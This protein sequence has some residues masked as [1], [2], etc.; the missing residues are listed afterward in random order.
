[1]YIN[2]A[3]Q[4]LETILIGLP[5]SPGGGKLIHGVEAN[6]ARRI[7]FVYHR[8][9]QA[10]RVIY[11]VKDYFKENTVTARLAEKLVGDLQSKD[12]ARQI[13]SLLFV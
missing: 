2:T 5:L 4:L 13:R 10:T 8:L 12:T 9:S 6:K 7:L 11:P 1:M 3:I